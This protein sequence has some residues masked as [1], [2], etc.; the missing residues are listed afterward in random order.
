MCAR[1]RIRSRSQNPGASSPRGP[2]GA[3]QL[4]GIGQAIEKQGGGNPGTAIIDLPFRAFHLHTFLHEAA[5][6]AAQEG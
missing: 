1:D 4:P 6:Q 5:D 3:R 2:T